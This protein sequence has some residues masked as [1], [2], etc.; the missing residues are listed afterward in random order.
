MLVLSERLRPSTVRAPAQ[1]KG[2]G[3]GNGPHEQPH[4]EV[5][6]KAGWH[7]QFAVQQQKDKT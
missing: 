6:T 5:N 4:K 7:T 1:I 3:L 2:G